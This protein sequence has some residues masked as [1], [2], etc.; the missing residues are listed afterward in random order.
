MAIKDREI[1]NRE[2]E[3]KKKETKIDGEKGREGVHN[4]HTESACVCVHVCTHICR[5]TKSNF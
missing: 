1:E 3:K 4:R 5:P 2:K